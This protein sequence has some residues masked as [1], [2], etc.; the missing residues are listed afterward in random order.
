MSGP[1]GI[2]YKAWRQLGELGVEIIHG[3]A[4]E[5]AGGKGEELLREAYHDEEVEEGGSHNFNL[6]T[7]LCLPKIQQCFVLVNVL[8]WRYPLYLL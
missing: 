4:K 7:I 2:A 8:G 5:L 6:S 1:D 3:M